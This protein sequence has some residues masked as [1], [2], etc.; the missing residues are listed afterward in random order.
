MILVQGLTE[1]SR[2]AFY[3]IKSS[4]AI[5]AHFNIQLHD[6]KEDSLHN[7]LYF[8]PVYELP[9]LQIISPGKRQDILQRGPGPIKTF[10]GG[11]R[12]ET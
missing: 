1:F 4:S 6:G 7:F 2:L 3:F 9:R 5:S 12:Q 10:R 8:I 11:F